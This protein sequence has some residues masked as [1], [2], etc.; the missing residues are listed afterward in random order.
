[1]VKWFA[2]DEVLGNVDAIVVPKYKRSN[3]LKVAHDGLGHLGYK[4][5]LKLSNVTLYGQG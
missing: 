4:K 5:V 3:I 2:R 1:M